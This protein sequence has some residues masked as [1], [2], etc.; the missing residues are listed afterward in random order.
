VKPLL[1]THY[2]IWTLDNSSELTAAARRAIENA[3]TVSFSAAS[4]WEIGLKWRKGKLNAEPREVFNAALA[5]GLQELSI[6]IDAIVLSAQ[7]PSPHGDPFD[8][9][10]YAQAKTRKLRLLTVDGE[11][12]KLGAVA[13]VL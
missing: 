6:D 12:A 11:I 4:I 7:L 5:A 2:S 10:M 9:L 3:E 8:R 13:L 1:D